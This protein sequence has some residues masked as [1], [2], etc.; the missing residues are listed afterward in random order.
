MPTDT[1]R[2]LTDCALRLFYR[3]GFRNVG[4]DQ[5]LEQV[6]ISKTAFYKHFESKDQLM[7]AALEEQN[8]RLQQSFR[9]RLRREG[10]RAARDQLRAL[11]D[12]VQQITENDEFQGCMFINVSIEFPRAHEPAHVAAVQSKHA[13]EELVF[14]I[15]ERAG[16]AAPE[17]LARELCLIMDG[18]YVGRQVGASTD[19][20]HTAR[21]L[22]ERVISAHLPD[23]A[24]RAG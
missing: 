18:A 5:V 14:E 8:E 23:E 15:A 1:R 17:L 12:V 4:L 19:T 13:I 21:R 16:A 11:F 22:A 3:D 7:L 2:M 20:I 9:E 10:G 24:S 6:G